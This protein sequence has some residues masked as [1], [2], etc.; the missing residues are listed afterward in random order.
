PGPL[1]ATPPARGGAKAG[2][3]D[4]CDTGTGTTLVLQT[5]DVLEPIDYAIVDKSKMA[6]E[7]AY[8]YG[9]AN[10]MFS[11]VLAY[12]KAKLSEAPKDWKDFWDLKKFPGGRTLRK[13]PNG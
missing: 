3:W 7:F 9:C 1:A 4:V 2:T 6:P 5:H 11:F 8:E 10:Y 12:N 13:Q